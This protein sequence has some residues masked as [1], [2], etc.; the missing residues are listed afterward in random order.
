MRLPFA[1]LAGF[2]PPLTLAA[3]QFINPP[4]A[5]VTGDF[6]G[7]MVF[8][9]KTWLKVMW[10]EPG[11]GVPTSVL[12]NQVNATTAAVFGEAERIT[13]SQ[14][15]MD[16][17]TWIVTTTKNLAV[18]NVFFFHIY[19]EGQGSPDGASH[20]F[21]ILPA[22]VPTL[23]A[24][25]APS[26]SISSST[27]GLAISESSTSS[28]VGTVTT[29]SSSPSG[30]STFASGKETS[31]SNSPSDVPV[32]SVGISQGA[33]I[34]LG[35]AIPSAVIIGVLAG[36][37]FFGRKKQQPIS[38]ARVESPS[39]MGPTYPNPYYGSNYSNNNT[40][41]GDVGSWAGYGSPGYDVSHFQPL[42]GGYKYQLQAIPIELHASSTTSELPTTPTRQY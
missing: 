34:G 9:E 13:Q 1:V 8:S 22:Q 17:F 15:N 19:Q 6:T 37:F 30:S 16:S 3:I 18:S 5:G 41:N 10:T 40:P 28:T 11:F 23:T 29:T 12:L 26:T 36:W 33:Q 21:N 38:A 7:N 4:P 31:Q 2:L 39:H 27:S 25:S 20:Y 42:P 14:V 24:S 35:V 32:S